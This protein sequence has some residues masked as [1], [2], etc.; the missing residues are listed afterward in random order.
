[1]SLL[2]FVRRMAREKVFFYTEVTETLDSLWEPGSNTPF[3]WHLAFV[4]KYFKSVRLEIHIVLKNA[5]PLRK[6]IALHCISLHLSLCLF[7]FS[8]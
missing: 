7:L 2:A 3:H 5:F 1:M 6:V 4:P 8:P